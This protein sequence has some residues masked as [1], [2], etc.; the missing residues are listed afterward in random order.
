MSSSTPVTN[1]VEWTEEQLDTLFTKTY[2]TNNK[3]SMSV[4][5]QK[6]LELAI[7]KYPRSIILNE[8]KHQYDD[9]DEST[10]DG[11][12]IHMKKRGR[13]HK[14]TDNDDCTSDVSEGNIKK[15]APASSSSSSTA[16]PKGKKGKK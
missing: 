5:H 7:I 3:T 15:T 11:N 12:D 16:P 14:I 13:K 4:D 1:V 9:D 6:L 10:S 8:W 2:G